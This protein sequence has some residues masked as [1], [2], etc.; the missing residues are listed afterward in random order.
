MKMIATIG[1]SHEIRNILLA[2]AATEVE[3][4]VVVGEMELEGPSMVALL[5]SKVFPPQKSS[6]D[7]Q[8][9]IRT[10]RFHLLIHQIEVKNIVINAHS[11]CINLCNKDYTRLPISHYK[12]KR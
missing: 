8:L 5:D 7:G 10:G 12:G 11:V 3:V 6:D 1:C 4:I 2:L 9:A